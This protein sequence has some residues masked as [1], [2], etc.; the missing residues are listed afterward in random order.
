MVGYLGEIGSERG[1][2]WRCGDSV[3]QREFLGYG[4][5]K[6]PPEHSA[7]ERNCL[8][9][10]SGLGEKAAQSTREV[11]PDLPPACAGIA[12]IPLSGLNRVPYRDLPAKSRV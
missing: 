3:S 9:L 6:T 8:K 11:R 1:I 12:S 2:A 7:F 4:L 10:K 5:A